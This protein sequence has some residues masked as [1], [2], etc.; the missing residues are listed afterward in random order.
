MIDIN[1]LGKQTDCV[2]QEIDHSFQPAIISMS[3][4]DLPPVVNSKLV[5][6]H[7]ADV[8]F[9]NDEIALS[10]KEKLQTKWYLSIFNGCRTHQFSF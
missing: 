1:L 3:N 4:D 2:S 8:R 6:K 7:V 10:G 9:L 5:V